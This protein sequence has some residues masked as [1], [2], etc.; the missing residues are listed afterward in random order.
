[1]SSWG[2]SYPQSLHGISGSCMVIPCTLSYPSGADTTGGIVAI[3]YKDYDSRKT[4][5]YHSTAP[6]EVDGH[7]RGRTQMLGDPLALNCT[8]LLREVTSGDSGPYRFR[9]EIVRDDRWLAAQDVVLSI[10]EDLDSPSV[11]PTED[12]TEGQKSILECSTPYVCP[13]GDIVLHWEGYNPQ[14]STVS[15]TVQL[16]TSMVSHNLTLNTTLSWRDHSKKLLC[17]LSFGSKKATRELVLRVRHSPKELQVLVSPSAQNIRVGDTVSLTC[18]VASSH[19]PVSGERVLTL[20]GFR[21][22]DHGQYLC[23]AQ[24]ALGAGSS[25]DVTLHV[26]AAE[27]SVSPSAEV[28]EG[29]ATTLSC[30]VPGQEGQDLNYTWYKNSAWLREGTSHTLLF[31]GVASSDSGYYSCKVTS[32]YGSDTSQTISLS[33]TYPPRN[34]T[35]RLFQ[36][37]QGGRLTII[38]CAVD[39]HPPATMAIDHHGTVLAASGSQVAPQQRFSVTATHN[40]LQLEIWDAGPQDNGEYRCT[41]SNTFGNT[42]ATKVLVIHAAEVL[43][44]PSAQVQEGTEVTLTCVGTGDRAEEPLYTWYKNGKWLQESSAPALHFPSVRSND[45]GAFQCQIRSSNGSDTSM[46]I[47]LR[48]L[49]PPRQP[50]MTSFLQTQGGH[51]GIIQCI[52]ESDPES[53]LTLWKG[54]DMIGCTWGCASAPSPRVH[55]TWSYNSLKVEIQEVVVEDEGTYVCCA[56]NTQGNSSASMDFRADTVSITVSPSHHLLEGDTANL[57]CHLSSDSSTAANVTWYHNGLWL[58][59]GLA[60]SLVIGQVASTDSGLYRCRASMEGGSR[61]SPDVLLDVL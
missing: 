61:S 36:E 54:E 8:L 25:P 47:P 27:I 2:V 18:E 12:Q 21:R 33:V 37:T 15:S 49:Y 22:E 48:V 43:I 7:F 24:N 28:Q 40:S 30:D 56:G 6:Q 35:L 4:L 1:L 59:E 58:S 3:W 9:F 31:P 20:R 51:L 55:I 29:T 44:Q 23:Q 11:A 16:D 45:A 34:P 38:H 5:V 10:S 57:T 52:V 60:T 42:S 19:P 13:W 17:E 53:N 39:S 41:A 46:A 32:S 50:V 26:L 14:V